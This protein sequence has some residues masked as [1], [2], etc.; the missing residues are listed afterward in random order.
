LSNSRPAEINPNSDFGLASIEREMQRQQHDAIASFNSAQ[1]IAKQIAS[2]ISSTG[3][4]ALLGMGSSH[5]VNRAAAVSYR[6]LGIDVQSEV[7]SE[8]LLAPF[9][10]LPRTVLVT[11]Q[12]GRSGEVVRY[13]E[14]SHTNEQRFGLTLDAEGPLALALPSLVGEGG[15]ETAFGAMRS[16]LV[17]LALHLA[18]MNALG[19][20]AAAAVK[21][22][23]SPPRGAVEAAVNHL[24]ACDT[25]VFSGRR[26]LQGLADSGALSLAELARIPT[27]GLEGGQL[28]HG[29]LEM[30][31]QKVGVIFLR[32]TGPAAQLTASLAEACVAAGSPVVVLD[33]SGDPPISDVVTIDLGRHEGMAAAFSI[34]PTLQPLLLSLAA[35]K[36]AN[37]GVPV[38]SGK[39]TTEL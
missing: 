31:S 24:A 22:L 38:R 5:W 12:S 36:V 14:T 23:E 16:V 33:A 11:S 19:G 28:R 29:P 7:L 8:I 18:V 6:A 32:P 2:S 26:E 1:V 35:R 21:V 3:R 37:V 17:S 34:L 25:M 9:S 27:L 13:L 10:P 30:L 4:L 20:D 39:V 15:V